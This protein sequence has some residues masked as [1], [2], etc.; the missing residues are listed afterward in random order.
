MR[1]TALNVY[2]IKSCAGTALETAELGRRGIVHDREFLVVD[3]GWRFLTQREHPRLALVR[4]ARTDATLTLHAPGMSP[5]ELEPVDGDRHLVTIWRDCVMAADQGDRVAEWLNE[6]LGAKCRLVRQPDDVVRA[7]DHAFAT[8]ATDEV[9]F[10][11]GYP[12]LLISEESLSDL[13]TRLEQPLPMNRFRPNIVVSG[14]DQAYVEDT[15]AEIRIGAVGF[16][17]VKACARCITTTTDQSTAERGHEPL[18]T[19]AT[20]RNVARGVLFGQNLIH[21]APGTIAVGDT[22]EVIRSAT[23]PQF[24]EA[25]RR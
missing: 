11:D 17:V 5:L 13:N 10:A 8:R 7:V 20:Y 23:P 15:W 18:A 16:S 4:P 14:A 1:V 2:P 12:V 21:S 3:V 9:S 25:A 22:L 24:L 6:Y 19:L